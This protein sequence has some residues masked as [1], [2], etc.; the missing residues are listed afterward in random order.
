MKQLCGVT[1]KPL[2]I[3]SPGADSNVLSSHPFSVIET[4]AFSK[5]FPQMPWLSGTT[6][7]S[8]GEGCFWQNR[9][10]RGMGRVSSKGL[11][12]FYSESPG[13]SQGGR[14]LW[15]SSAVKQQHHF[16]SK[17]CVREWQFQYGAPALA[18]SSS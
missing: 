12:P 16:C 1:W 5:G 18:A 11:S 15:F 9:V 3:I 8:Q 13:H 4:Q 14:G 6:V 10:S 2:G 17:C 7:S